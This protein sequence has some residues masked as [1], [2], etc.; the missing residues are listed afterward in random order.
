[1]KLTIISELL[2]KI[3]YRLREKLFNITYL[4]MYIPRC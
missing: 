2:F 3:I 4:R 1:M